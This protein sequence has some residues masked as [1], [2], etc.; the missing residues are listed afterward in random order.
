MHSE[1]VIIIGG[2]PAGIA[3]AIQLKRYGID[4]LL[5]ERD[6]VGGL[7][8]NAWRLDNYP[9]YPD[10][11]AG[12]DLVGKLIRHLGRFEIRTLKSEIRTLKFSENQ[13]LLE[14]EEEVFQCE[15]M[16]V[17]TGTRSKY[18]GD[19]FTEVYPLRNVKGKR[20]AIVGAGDA[21][22]DYAMTLSPHNT[23]HIHNRG[24][25]IKCIPALL[26]IARKQENIEYFENSSPTDSY[27][28]TI[29]ATGREPDLGCMSDELKEMQSGLEQQG[30]LYV[31][32]DV[33]NGM[34]RQTSVATGDGIK[35]AM[36]I[37]EGIKADE[38]NQQDTGT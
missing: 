7:V 35:A 12:I 5:I 14:S 29:F 24:M 10:G 6:E 37:V 27:D 13:F 32:G 22:F 11:I 2:G 15:F 34:V 25:E 33:K 9:G 26:D 4:P 28:Y 16:V 38:G 18:S 21:A 19:R 17:A 23:V 8:K 3:C 31:I 30:I 20:I 1:K 36:A